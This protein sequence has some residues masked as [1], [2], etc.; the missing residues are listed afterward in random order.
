MSGHGNTCRVDAIRIGRLLRMLRI[1]R[2]WRQ[3]DVAERAG[4]S[5]AVIGRHENGA[6]QSFRPAERHAAVFGVRIDLRLS[7]RGGDLPR[8]VDE[9]HASI[10]EVL[11]AWCR[12]HGFV[13]EVE[14]SFSQ[15]GERGRFDL[16]AWNAATGTLLVIEVK[17]ELADLQDLFGTLDA[18]ERIASTIAQ[19]RGWQATR[20]VTLLVVANTSLNRRVVARHP[21][22]FAGWRVS[23]LSVP[24]VVRGGRQ[25]IWM[26]AGSAQ[27]SAWTAGRQRVRTRNGR[28]PSA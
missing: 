21:A 18:K 4:V 3:V 8:L 12:A 11:A 10:G 15:W 7:G 25:L 5:P 16:I 19:R 2:S 1:R 6:F 20:R 14:T 13:V 28:S 26:A 27:R 22:L 17:T 24:A 23:R 9:E